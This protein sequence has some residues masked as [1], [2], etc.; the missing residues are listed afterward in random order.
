M[1][2]F[3]SCTLFSGSLPSVDGVIEYVTAC[4][5]TG[6]SPC[7][8]S[9]ILPVMKCGSFDIMYHRYNGMCGRYCL[10]KIFHVFFIL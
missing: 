1:V 4:E 10:G 8:Y 5:A 2:L 7:T 9:W 3:S 6:T